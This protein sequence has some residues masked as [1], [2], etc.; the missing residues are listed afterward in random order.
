MKGR[1]S[2]TVVQALRDEIN[3]SFDAH[4]LSIAKEFS[5]LRQ[6]TPLRPRACSQRSLTSQPVQWQSF[7]QL[8]ESVVLDSVP[9]P[10]TLQQSKHK[11]TEISSRLTQCL[12]KRK[13]TDRPVDLHQMLLLWRQAARVKGERKRMIALVLARR[14]RAAL[15]RVL[16]YWHAWS[17]T[18]HRWHDAATQLHQISSIAL[19]SLAY[20]RWRTSLSVRRTV[21]GLQARRAVEQQRQA[22]AFWLDSVCNQKRERR[23]S[24]QCQAR[25]KRRV[26]AIW[27][28]Y[29]L[30]QRGKRDRLASAQ[31]FLLRSCW[32]RWVQYHQQSVRSRDLLFAVSKLRDR[33]VAEESFNRWCNYVET[34]K[35]STFAR[36]WR[37]Q[38]LLADIVDSWRSA[39][40]RMRR[41]RRI[42]VSAARRRQRRWLTLCMDSWWHIV[43]RSRHRN[44]S[45][46]VGQVSFAL[47]GEY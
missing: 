16:M 30:L 18:R 35:R 42:V 33:L 38:H 21:F 34:K 15:Y 45:L 24:D 27:H 1:R 22:F 9:S 3:A 40:L 26:V 44:S 14:S 39:Q 6:Q 31:S 23:F 20:T 36:A 17:S 13:A 8:L 5:S 28:E 43:E 19:L 25:R 41:E 32:H 29:A 12:Q 46:M 37:N 4:K 7:D 10:R 2:D 47:V 11:K